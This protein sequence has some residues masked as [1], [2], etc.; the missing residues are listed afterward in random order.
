MVQVFALSSPHREGPRFSRSI[1]VPLVRPTADTRLLVEAAAA[2]MRAIYLPGFNL[3]KAGVILMDLVGPDIHQD[4]L[5][6][7]DP[8]ERDLGPLMSALDGLNAR[9]GKGTVHVASTGQTHANQDWSM[10]QERRTPR[11]TTEWSELPTA[12]A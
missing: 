2:G 3:I 1:V 12:R 10:R 11:Y 6:F 8:L 9:Y 7:E 5:A 4:E